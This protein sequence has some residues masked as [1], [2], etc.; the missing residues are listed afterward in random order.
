MVGL[1]STLCTKRKKLGALDK[2]SKSGENSYSRAMNR[3][4][5]TGVFCKYI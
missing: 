2:K 3:G 5:S 4:S 1:F